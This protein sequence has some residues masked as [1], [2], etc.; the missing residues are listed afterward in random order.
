MAPVFIRSLALV[1]FAA[2]IGTDLTPLV[3]FLIY[4]SEP[5]RIRYPVQGSGELG[6]FKDGRSMV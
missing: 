3:S 2:V 5:G 1:A 6:R 4:E